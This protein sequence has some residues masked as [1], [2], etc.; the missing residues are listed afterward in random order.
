[1]KK[2]T[3]H[4]K[5]ETD[6]GTNYLRKKL[7]IWGEHSLNIRRRHAWIDFRSFLSKP[8]VFTKQIFGCDVYWGISCKYLGAMRELFDCKFIRLN[9]T[10]CIPFFFTKN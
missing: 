3:L 4:K 7:Q 6:I 9:F 10:K 8:W 5:T 2:R 1:M